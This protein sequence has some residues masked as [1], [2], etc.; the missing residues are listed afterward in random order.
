MDRKSGVILLSPA[1]T[2]MTTGLLTTGLLTTGLLT[3]GLLT[4]DR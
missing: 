4:A 2:R 1:F 3:T